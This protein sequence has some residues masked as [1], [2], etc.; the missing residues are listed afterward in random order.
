[1]SHTEDKYFKGRGA[2]I[3]TNNP[4]STKKYVNDNKESIDEDLL[5]DEKTIFIN[6][7]PKKIIN[8]IKSPDIP[9]EYSMNP[10]QGCEHGCIYCYARNSHEYWGYSAGLDFER[11][12][13]V[14]PDAPKLLEKQ[15]KAPNHKASP[16][17]LSGNTDCYQPVEKKLMLT[18]KMLEVLLKYKH[19]VSIITKNKLIL[20]D[21]DILYELAKLRLVHVYI[22]I[23][24]LNEELRLRM[25]PRTATGFNRIKLIQALSEKHIPTGVMCAPIIPG[26]N[27]FEIPEIIKNAA[28]AGALSAGYTLVRLTGSLKEIFTDWLQKNYPDKFYKVIHQIQEIHQGN[29]TNNEFGKRMTGTGNMALMINKLFKASVNKYLVNKQMPAYN[30]QVFYDNKTTVNPQLKMFTDS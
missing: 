13:L 12:I 20:R 17:L 1:M 30:T 10:Y 2:Q 8:H 4:Y 24:T 28:E 22:S 11:K 9:A 25:E 23:T 19:P 26:L 16:I 15:L 14:K 18:R 27:S 21:T 3:N 6:E 29:F 7:Y 5:C